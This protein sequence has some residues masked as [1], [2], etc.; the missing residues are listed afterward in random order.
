MYVKTFCLNSSDLSFLSAAAKCKIADLRAHFKNTYETARFVKGMKIPRAIQYMERVLAHEQIIPFRKFTGGIGR[1]AQVKV[2][3]A[4][5]GRWPEK[6]T[7][8]VRELLINLRANAE[9]KGLDPE[10]CVINH[11]VV[12]RAVSGRR[13]TYRAH[14]RITPY[15]SSNCHIEF[16]CLER[17][18]PV[19]KADKPVARITKKQAARQRLAIGK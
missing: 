4:A 18:G 1:H 19:A 15:L 11:V 17:S 2:H 14:G 16:H 3:K 9:T 5:T 12:Q 13:R 6:S 7:K 8:A 10:K